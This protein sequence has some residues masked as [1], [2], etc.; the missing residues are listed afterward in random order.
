MR[1]VKKLV[2]FTNIGETSAM[3]DLT[4]SILEERVFYLLLLREHIMRE[5]CFGKRH[6]RSCNTMRSFYEMVMLQEELIFLTRVRENPTIEEL[7]ISSLYARILRWP[8]II[9]FR[10]FWD[11]PGLNFIIRCFSFGTS[12]TPIYSIHDFAMSSILFEFWDISIAWSS[13]V[14]HMRRFWEEPD[15]LF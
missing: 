12:P 14:R 11:G 10:D 15:F 6:A 8:E 9:V 2:C 4:S 7:R 3:R 13:R 1:R 5:E